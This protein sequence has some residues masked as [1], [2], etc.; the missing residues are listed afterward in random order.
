MCEARK[1]V[2]VR[3]GR[4]GVNGTREVGCVCETREREGVSGTRE[5]G[6]VCETRERG[7]EWNKGGR[8]CV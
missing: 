6:C 1:E 4:E 2:E 8:V 3:Q 5:V 7:C